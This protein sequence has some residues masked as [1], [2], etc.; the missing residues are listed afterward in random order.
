MKILCMKN[1][2][3]PFLLTETLA[4]HI[5]TGIHDKAMEVI[6]IIHMCIFSLKH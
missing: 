4:D 5:P 1:L 2:I 6:V 3:D